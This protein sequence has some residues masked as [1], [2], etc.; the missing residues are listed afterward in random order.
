[1]ASTTLRHQVYC[2]LDPAAREH[3]GLSLT[4]KLLVVLI[5]LASAQAIVETEPTIV[6]GREELFRSTELMFGLIFSVEYLARLWIAPE[7]PYCS[8]QRYPRLSYVFTPSALIDL[9]AILPTLLSMGMTGALF[10]RFFRVLRI[11]RLAKLGRMSSAWSDLAAALHSRRYELMLTVML[12]GVAILVSSTMLYLAEGGVQPDKFGSIPRSFW[13]SVVT[14][15]TVGYGDAFPVTALGKVFAGVVAIMGIGLIAIPS[16]ILASAF[17]ET[18]QRRR[19]RE[20]ER[21]KKTN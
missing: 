4:N 17:S 21:D 18:L 8:K 15:T 6:A 12:A 11:F 16:G 5:I 3:R 9:A 2:E 20:L 1:M 13:W 7:N 19:Q 14:L 10:L